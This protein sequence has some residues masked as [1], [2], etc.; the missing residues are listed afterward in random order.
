MRTIVD[1]HRG[2]VALESSPGGGTRIRVQLPL[3][4]AE[5]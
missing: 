4:R 1:A 3:R 5:S 2:R